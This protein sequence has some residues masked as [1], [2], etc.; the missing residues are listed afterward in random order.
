[1]CI[2]GKVELNDLKKINQ[3]VK[4]K[5]IHYK[6]ININKLYFQNNQTWLLIKLWE[7]KNR[8]IRNICNYFNWD[9]IKL[10]R[11]QFG[12]YKLNN[13]SVGKIKEI[14]IQNNA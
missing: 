6:K 13:L 10:I 2:K 9:I 11:I 12:S 14:K 8:E 4:I 5:K 7:G 1:M 3:G